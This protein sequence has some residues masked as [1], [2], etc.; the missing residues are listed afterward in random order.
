MIKHAYNNKID[1]MKR[2][3]RGLIIFAFVLA[4][5]GNAKKDS[6]GDLNDK[7]GKLE[8]LKIQQ[9]E[10][11]TQIVTLEAEI[12]KADT[13]ASKND[14]AKLVAISPVQPGSFTHY[15]D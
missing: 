15:I 4:S 10:I 3:L 11:A 13:S 7:K 1:Q 12:A 5:C 6:T 14:N 9:K 8:K 2:D